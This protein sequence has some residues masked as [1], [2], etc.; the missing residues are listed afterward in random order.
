MSASA[1]SRAA[2]SQ[3][4]QFFLAGKCT[5]GTK[6]RYDHV[7]PKASAPASTGTS[8][9]RAGAGAAKPAP[10]PAAPRAAAT[11][12]VEPQAGHAPAPAAWSSGNAARQLLASSSSEPDV[13]EPASAFRAAAGAEAENAAHEGAALQGAQAVPQLR[14]EA[15][16]LRDTETRAA[17]ATEERAVTQERAA[18]S[19]EARE[20]QPQRTRCAPARR[21][22]RFIIS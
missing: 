14:G 3:V 7:R 19:R 6:C 12:A 20:P 18:A 11:A 10:P 16:F 1:A 5:Y 13:S 8:T 4:C 2:S 22:T 21:F 15:L 17:A 9:S